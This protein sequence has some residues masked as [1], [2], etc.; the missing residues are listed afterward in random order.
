MGTLYLLLNASS[1]STWQGYYK[2]SEYLFGISHR[3]VMKEQYHQRLVTSLG[4]DTQDSFSRL[5]SST[6]SIESAWYTPVSSS[7][8]EAF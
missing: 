4:G 3:Y 2:H 8:L 5:L 6:T 7:R 1:P